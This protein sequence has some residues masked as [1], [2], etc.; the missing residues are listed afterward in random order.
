MKRRLPPLLA[1]ALVAGLCPALLSF[2]PGSKGERTLAGADSYK[3]DNTHSTAIFRVRHLGVG[4]AYGRF[5]QLAGQI[6]LDEE[7][8]GGC[9]IEVE[10]QTDSLDSNNEGRDDH[11]KGPDFLSAKE[12]PT[13]SFKSTKVEESE[14]G[15]TVTGDLT[16]HGV[17]HSE[18][19]E[20]AFGG[21]VQDPWGNE[22]VGFEAVFEIDP[23][24]YEI[25]YMAE[26]EM[27][28][29]GIRIIISVEATR[30]P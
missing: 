14:G 22:R 8:P 9:S 24:D 20:V 29:P 3:L 30:R 28:G 4:Y 10:I 1:V 13:L 25:R 15:Y 27:L 18:T 12:F 2:A 11:I 23:T 19:V 6:Q 26:S 7:D 5:N 16:L 17:T 21:K